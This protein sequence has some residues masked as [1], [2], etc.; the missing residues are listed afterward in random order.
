MTKEYSRVACFCSTVWA[1]RMPAHYF[2]VLA[3]FIERRYQCRAKRLQIIVRCLRLFTGRMCRFEACTMSWSESAQYSEEIPEL[4][5]TL[6]LAVRAVRQ[7]GAAAET[8][9]GQEHRSTPAANF[10]PQRQPWLSA[11]SAIDTCRQCVGTSRWHSDTAYLLC[12][13]G[14]SMATLFCHYAKATTVVCCT[15][16]S[17]GSR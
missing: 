9:V 2:Q 14:C 7:T 12:P 1:S 11:T 15:Y 13:D 6:G 8:A 3:L 17:D 16:M 4:A 10:A 5:A